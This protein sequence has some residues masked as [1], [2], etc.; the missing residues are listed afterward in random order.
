[1]RT[2]EAFLTFS[3][4]HCDTASPAQLDNNLIILIIT[5]PIHIFILHLVPFQMEYSSCPDDQCTAVEQVLEEVL[6]MTPNG[7]S[8]GRPAISVLHLPPSTKTVCPSYWMR[9]A[10]RDPSFSSMQID[11]GLAGA[12]QDFVDILYQRRHQGHP[13][14]SWT[15]ASVCILCRPLNGQWYFINGHYG[16]N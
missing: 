6:L 13:I 16:C 5:T 2:P 11:R 8:R 7:A 4:F 10:H 9:S 1:M 14:M 15:I 12:W 3:V